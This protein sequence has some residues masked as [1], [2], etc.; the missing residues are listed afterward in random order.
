MHSIYI[1]HN[2]ITQFTKSTICITKTKSIQAFS[3]HTSQI[4]LVKNDKKQHYLPLLGRSSNL[5][6]QNLIS[7]ASFVSSRLKDSKLFE[8]FVNV[9]VIS[10][11]M[12]IDLFYFLTKIHN[13]QPCT[14]YTRVCKSLSINGSFPN[15]C[16]TNPY[17]N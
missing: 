11:K 16:Q 5:T 9:V 15:H 6:W 1:Y 8:F 2:F 4:N 17:P 3:H 12:R 10:A 7:N 13:I 14:P